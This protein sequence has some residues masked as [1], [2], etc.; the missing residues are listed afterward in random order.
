MRFGRHS[1]G[2]RRLRQFPY[3]DAISKV[4]SWSTLNDT[5]RADKAFL[6]GR[7]VQTA[8]DVL[9]RASRELGARPQRDAL[10]L[11]GAVRLLDLHAGGV[12]AVC[13]DRD[14]ASAQRCG[15]QS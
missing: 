11:A 3:A 7:I 10:E 4:G 13:H 2:K 12:V 8:G 15:Y 6:G 1:I 9:I 5:E 14:P